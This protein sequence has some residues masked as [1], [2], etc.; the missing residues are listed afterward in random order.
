MKLKNFLQGSYTLETPNY[1]CERTINWYP[2]M[3]EMGDAKESEPMMLSPTPGLT[4]QHTLPRSPIRGLY[5]TANNFIYC[6]AGNGLFLLTPTVSSTGNSG[7][8]S[9]SHALLA[10]LTTSSG[11][12]SIIDGIPN[13]YQGISNTGLINQVVVVDGSTTGLVFQEGTN[14]VYTIGSASGYY[15]SSGT[16]PSF[17]SLTVSAT[18]TINGASAWYTKV[19]S[20]SALTAVSVAYTSF[21]SGANIV[22]NYTKTTASACVLT[23]PS[24]TI[25]K[26]DGVI[27]SGVAVTLS[28][29][30]VSQFYIQVE[31]QNSGYVVFVDQIVS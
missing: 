31:A 13:Y 26:Q 1:S 15:G 10:Y 12:V 2:D 6:V 24:G 21:T 25:I 17:A 29:T 5:K 18:T 22:W 8:L 7:N 16:I 28:G 11:Y 9:W 4:L 20:S 3:S 30:N 23:F 14:Q 19:Y 27:I